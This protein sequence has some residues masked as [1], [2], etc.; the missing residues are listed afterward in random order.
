MHGLLI[1]GGYSCFIPESA[2]TTPPQN[3]T[4]TT[5]GRIPSMQKCKVITTMNAMRG[6]ARG[7][8]AGFNL[9]YM[10]VLEPQ[11]T[12]A[13]Q[14]VGWEFDSRVHADNFKAYLQSELPNFIASLQKEDNH[15]DGCLKFIPMPDVSQPWSDAQ[16]QLQFGFTA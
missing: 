14:L 8:A 4:S 11:E 5:A 13:G 1:A 3:S 9:N 6:P 16:L 7:T 10:V 12:F 15:I 2:A